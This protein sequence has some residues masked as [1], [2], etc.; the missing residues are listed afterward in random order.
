MSLL[1]FR[2]KK[3]DD[4]TMK[5]LNEWGAKVYGEAY[6]HY[7]KMA[8]EEN[9]NVAIIFD[10]WWHGKSVCATEY[11]ENFSEEE[12]K[13]AGEIILTAVSHGFG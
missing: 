10:D 3:L 2:K 11:K 13:R 9:E 5:T 12:N 7:L 6:E 1:G 8:K 4:K